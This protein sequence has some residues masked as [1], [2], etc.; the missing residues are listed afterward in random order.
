MT[1]F[2][3]LA[4][5]CL[6]AECTLV[7]IQMLAT[8]FALSSFSWKSLHIGSRRDLL[9]WLRV[10][11]LFAGVLLTSILALKEAPMSLTITFRCLAP[12][13]ALMIEQFY[14]NPLIVSREMLFWLVVMMTGAML[15]I[16]DM[17]LSDLHAVGWVMLNNGF[18]VADRLLQRLMLAKDQQPVDISKSACA[19]LNN[20]FGVL[21]LCVI[22]LFSEEYERAIPLL[23]A[24]DWYGIALISLTCVVGCSIAY[25]GIWLQSL[26]SAT[27][28]LVLATGSKFFVIFIEVFVMRTKSLTH[29]QITGATLTILAGVASG[30]VRQQMEATSQEKASLLDKEQ[31]ASGTGSGKAV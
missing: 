14:P 10:A 3:K 5:K 31:T 24:L 29:L 17:S 8:V 6:P 20:L 26:I 12:V 22:V 30:K 23:Q 9:L 28:F 1:V 15:Y 19:L 18:V 13:F 7:A 4:I 21:P 16:K 11:P 27:S 2:N 25:S